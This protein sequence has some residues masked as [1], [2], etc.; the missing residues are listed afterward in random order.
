MLC[1]AACN[2]KATGNNYGITQTNVQKRKANPRFL[3]PVT[4]L[5]SSSSVHIW[6][7]SCFVP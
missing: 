2:F 6:P 3:V 1:Q 7:F 5:F 4:M